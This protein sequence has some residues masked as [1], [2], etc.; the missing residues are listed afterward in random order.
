MPVHCS[1][2]SALFGSLC[3]VLSLQ[4]DANI[5]RPIPQRSKN[6]TPTIRYTPYCFHLE[7]SVPSK[8]RTQLGRLHV[9][10]CRG[11]AGTAHRV[12]QSTCHKAE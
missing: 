12:Q 2:F 1:L 3:S 7:L 9:P 6:S 11:Q 8:R 5:S 10:G 4:W